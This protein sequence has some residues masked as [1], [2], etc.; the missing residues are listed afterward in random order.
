[1]NFYYTVSGF[2]HDIKAASNVITKTVQRSDG[3][4]SSGPTDIIASFDGSWQRRG[5]ASLTS[6]IVGTK[7]KPTRNNT[8]IFVFSLINKID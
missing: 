4:V 2:E 3:T 5:Y 8:L 1:L 7:D 6:N